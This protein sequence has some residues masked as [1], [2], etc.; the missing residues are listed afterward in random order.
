MF[1]SVKDRNKNLKK[2]SRLT[3]YCVLLQ[4]QN[5]L[6]LKLSGACERNRSHAC[7]PKCQCGTLETLIC[8]HR[9]VYSGH[10]IARTAQAQCVCRTRQIHIGHGDDDFDVFHA[11]ERILLRGQNPLH[12]LL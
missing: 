5:D 10:R 12:I 3:H 2:Y 9:F 6:F 11:D 4:K 8:Y 1:T 7:V